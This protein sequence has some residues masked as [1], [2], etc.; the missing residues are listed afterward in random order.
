MIQVKDLL[1]TGRG[2]CGLSKSR[3]RA[4]YFVKAG[5]PFSRTQRLLRFKVPAVETRSRQSSVPYLRAK[6]TVS[7]HHG[8]SGS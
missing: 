1:R 2:A 5:L 8:A 7:T 6:A 4:G 3:K